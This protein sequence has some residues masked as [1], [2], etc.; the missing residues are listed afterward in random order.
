MVS[1]LEAGAWTVNAMHAVHDPL[2]AAAMRVLDADP[3][4]D[5]MQTD[6]TGCSSSGIG[7]GPG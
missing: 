4:P 5:A 3:L 7:V 2:I 6:D 1:R